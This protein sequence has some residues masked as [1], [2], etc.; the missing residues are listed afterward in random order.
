MRHAFGV[1]YGSGKDNNHFHC[2]FTSVKLLEQ[3]EKVTDQKPAKRL[4][5]FKPR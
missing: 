4:V 2:G 1:N 5:N 3:I